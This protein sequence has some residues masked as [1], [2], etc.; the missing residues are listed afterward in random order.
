[1]VAPIFNDA[2]HVPGIYPTPA[3]KMSYSP[4]QTLVHA[5]IEDLEAYKRDLCR[6]RLRFDDR[7]TDKYALE[8]VIVL[9]EE[10]MEHIDFLDTKLRMKKDKSEELECENQM[11]REANEELRGENEE[12]KERIELGIKKG[13]SEDEE[14]EDDASR[15]EGDTLRLENKILKEDIKGFEEEIEELHK[16]NEAL[17]REVEALKKE[18]GTPIAEAP[19]PK[20][21][22]AAGRFSGT[23]SPEPCLPT[24]SN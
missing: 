21:S 16:K 7:E 5:P 2:Q 22:A 4:Y 13:K 6:H 17:E 15:T 24:L 18:I 10:L 11:F 19:T 14:D 23:V 8:E 20:I 1:M 12:L 9:A 3:V